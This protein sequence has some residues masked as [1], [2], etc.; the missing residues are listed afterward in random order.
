[1]QK[2]GENILVI[3]IGSGSVG[4]GLLSTFS[5]NNTNK[6]TLTFSTRYELEYEDSVNF[7][8]L[9]QKML[10]G[11]EM[12]LKQ[13]PKQS[14]DKIQIF[15]HSPWHTINTKNISVKEDS[16]FT[17]NKNFIENISEKE[18][19]TFL[20]KATDTMPEYHNLVLVESIV[21][22]VKVNGYVVKNNFDQKTTNCDIVLSMA[23]AP[24][25]IVVNIKKTCT[26]NISI[27]ERNISFHSSTLAFAHICGGLYDGINDIMLIDIGSEITDISLIKNKVLFFGVS[28]AGGTHDI[29]RNVS[30]T[31]NT[32]FSDA[33][34][35]THASFSGVL[36]N[37][38]FNQINK[39]LE[40]LEET[41][42]KSIS[43][44]LTKIPSTEVIPKTI[45]LICEDRALTSW[46]E[47]TIK[48]DTL[49][50]YLKTDGKFQVIN[51]NKDA[52]KNNIHIDEN[53][54]YI[55]VS[56]GLLCISI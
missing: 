21:A 45:V 37:S 12:G 20:Q 49:T 15:L 43:N 9:L 23:F 35:K 27:N 10:L 30:N 53:L 52:L 7:D 34:S 46:Y 4:L 26:K 54:K 48:S 19:K 28:F 22:E 25:D 44:S 16:P 55:D 1:M 33:L 32:N 29:I 47:K 38:L 36:N 56:L 18:I 42:Q 6:N 31:L 13:L 11:I 51:I 17:V 39:S 2:D 3:D 8:T 24:S 14:V 50:Q 41:W 40:P 5:N